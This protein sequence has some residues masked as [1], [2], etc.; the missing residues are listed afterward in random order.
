M[1]PDSTWALVNRLEE[2][3]IRHIFH[4]E[5]TFENYLLG[6][7]MKGRNGMFPVLLAV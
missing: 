2:T 7:I 4:K 5:M 1:N 3:A 6:L